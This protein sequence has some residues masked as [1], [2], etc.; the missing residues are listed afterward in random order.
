MSRVT[1][2]I[3]DRVTITGTFTQSGA[4]VDPVNVRA[5]YCLT[6]GETKGTTTTLVYP[7]G[8]SKLDVGIYS[9]QIPVTAAGRYSYRMDD[10][11]SD[12]VIGNVATEG[13]FDV[14]ASAV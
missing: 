1:Y 3:G 5:K 11:A 9:F 4:A 8:I 14:E 10:A 13:W 12:A 6:V 2:D 7:V